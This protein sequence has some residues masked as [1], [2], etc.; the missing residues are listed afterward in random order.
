MILELVAAHSFF[1]EPRLRIGAIQHCGP[2]RLAV[3]DRFFQIAPDAIGDEERFILTIGRLVVADLRSALPRRPQVLAFT[4]DVVGH[5]RRRRSQYALRGAVILFQAD[6]LCLGKIFLKFENVPNIRPA[7]G[8]DRLVLV[9]H[10]TQVVPG[11]REQAHQFVLRTVR[12][13]IFV[14]QNVLESPVV[15][16]AHRSGGFQQTQRLEQQVVEVERVRLAQFL[17]IFL[18]N[19]RNL[20]G[21]GIGRLQVNFLRIQ[22]VVLRPRNPAQCDAGRK[23]LV[24]NPHPLHDRLYDALLVGLVVDDEIFGVPDGRLSRNGRG[25]PQRLDIPP[26]HPHAERVEGRD[27]GLRHGKPAHDALHAFDHLGRGLVRE[28]HRE[29]RLR[30]HPKVLDEVRDAVGDD[31]RLPAARARQ[32]QHRTVSGLD[33]LA[34]LGIELI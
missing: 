3:L 28:R 8:V 29:N 24:V 26:Q 25:N 17:P 27:H 6:D 23:F 9:S 32:N 10:C 13:L 1:K 11:A 18:V 12:V 15:I 22:H 20:L 16:I 34:L 5:H 21:L 7:P 14:D 4:L 2:R 30:H 31:A 33:S 19:V